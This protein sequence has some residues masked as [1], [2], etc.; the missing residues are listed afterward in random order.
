MLAVE[1]LRADPAAL[2]P[3]LDGHLLG[4]GAVT[5]DAEGH[6]C[7][8]PHGEHPRHEDGTH[9]RE[10]RQP[11]AM[12]APTKSTRKRR[13]PNRCSML[14]IAPVLRLSMIVTW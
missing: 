6:G 3:A 13:R 14:A 9:D 7:R 12:P 2:P 8:H 5:A 10:R 4:L 11:P 1:G